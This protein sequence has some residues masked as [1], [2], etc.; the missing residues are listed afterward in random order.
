MR[1]N[2]LHGIGFRDRK[3]SLANPISTGAQTTKKTELGYKRHMAAENRPFKSQSYSSSS[4][5]AGLFRYR[6]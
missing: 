3:G 5:L 1:A 2:H 6:A 4:G